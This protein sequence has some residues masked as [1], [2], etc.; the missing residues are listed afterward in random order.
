MI[1]LYLLV[2]GESVL[3]ALLMIFYGKKPKLEESVETNLIIW[4]SSNQIGE[5][6]FILHHKDCLRQTYGLVDG[7]RNYFFVRFCVNV[8]S[9]SP[10]TFDEMEQTE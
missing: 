4:V 1:Q 10:T 5:S 6:V 9:D 8:F 2:K 7:R 3:E